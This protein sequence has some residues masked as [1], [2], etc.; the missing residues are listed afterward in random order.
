MDQKAKTLVIIL[1]AVTFLSI[2]IAYIQ[3]L[4]LG[5]VLKVMS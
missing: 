2:G 4:G 3:Y 5:D 1:L